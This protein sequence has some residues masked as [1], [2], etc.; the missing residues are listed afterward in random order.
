LD[1]KWDKA[2]KLLLSYPL[3]LLSQE[4]TPL[5]FLYGCWLHVTEGKD[6]ASIHFFGV[7]EVSY[8]RSWALFSHYLN[9]KIAE[10][11]G[12]FEKAFL[13]EKRQIYKQL[14][15][16]YQCIGDMERTI[17]YQHLE[18]QQYLRA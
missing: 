5:H 1:K 7:M 17:H 10:G 9:G 4:T 3:E 14:I 11:E 13:W 6:I 2:G 12:W 16:F 18:K 15:L 8:P